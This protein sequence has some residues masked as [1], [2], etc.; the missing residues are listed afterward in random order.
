MYEFWYDYEKPKYGENANLC[1]MDTDRFIV[2][3]KAEEICADI[4]NN[5]KVRFNTSNYKLDRPLPKTKSH[6]K[7]RV[8]KKT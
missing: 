7:V 4:A 8:K 3:K 6:K 1:Y 2:Y 5:V